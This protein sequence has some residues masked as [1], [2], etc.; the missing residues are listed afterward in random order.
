MVKTVA[1]N[2]VP[3]ALR[4]TGLHVAAEPIDTGVWAAVRSTVIAGAAVP[5]MRPCSLVLALEEADS[6]AG[7]FVPFTN[8]VGSRRRA[9]DARGVYRSSFL[10]GPAWGRKRFMRATLRIDGGPLIVGVLVELF[11]DM[12]M[13]VEHGEFESVDVEPADTAAGSEPPGDA[14]PGDAAL[15]DRRFNE[16][17]DNRGA[18]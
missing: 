1:I 7:P 12:R 13:L 11:A 2:H 6:A 16:F 3:P 14:V 10:L 5:G 18:A 8:G 17:E 15:G 4:A 9:A